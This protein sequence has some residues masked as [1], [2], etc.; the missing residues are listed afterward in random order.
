MAVVPEGVDEPADTARV[1]SA[2]EAAAGGASI[3]LPLTLG[4]AL[5]VPRLVRCVRKADRSCHVS[6]C[7]P[8]R[9]L[10]I[11]LPELARTLFTVVAEA[12]VVMGQGPETMRELSGAALSV[13][14]ARTVF[15]TNTWTS[16]S[17]RSASPCAEA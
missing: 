5:D 14:I 13:I 9:A 8:V 11:T 3:A 12:C 7:M 4:L 15:R 16:N 1:P 2:A 6:R 17:Y 10:Y